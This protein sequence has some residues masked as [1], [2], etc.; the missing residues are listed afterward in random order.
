MPSPAGTAPKSP[1]LCRRDTLTPPYQ[2]GQNH[3]YLYHEKNCPYTSLNLSAA[4]ASVLSSFAKQKR[5][6]L[7][8]AW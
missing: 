6:T 2:A 3:V 8:S 1:D 7:W 4:T 5:T